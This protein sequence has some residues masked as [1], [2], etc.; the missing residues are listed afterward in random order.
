MLD[1]CSRR[2]PYWM[3]EGG[4]GLRECIIAGDGE[5]V[6]GE[7]LLSGGDGDAE[8]VTDGDRD[9][10]VDEE[11]EAEDEGDDDD[12]CCCCCGGF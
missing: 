9:D 8:D 2:D 12:I 3:D 1:C 4:D 7:V 5:G 10:S 11:E 6:L